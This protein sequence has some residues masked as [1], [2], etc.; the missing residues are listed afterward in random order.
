[1]AKSLPLDEMT[2]GEKLAAMELL[3]ED[4]SASPE[5]FES[6]SWHKELL[7]ERRQRIA[8]GK[9]Q[10]VDWEAAKVEI[11]KKLS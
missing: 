10:F 11:R 9:A 3:W 1:M 6:P 5:R 2:L 7:D 8:E 4:I